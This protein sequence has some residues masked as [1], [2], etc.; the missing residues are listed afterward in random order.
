MLLTN[1][2]CP[3]CRKIVYWINISIPFDYGLCSICNNECSI[4]LSLMITKNPN[5]G[6]LKCCNN[7]ICYYCYKHIKSSSDLYSYII[8]RDYNN[9][10]R[11]YNNSDYINLLSIS[12]SFEYYNICVKWSFIINKYILTNRD[13]TQYIYT[14]NNL[15]PPKTPLNI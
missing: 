2:Q 6:I 10:N 11:N 3:Y 4:L 5:E 13:E 1:I 15:Y 7:K 9:I 12:T 8:D 14:L